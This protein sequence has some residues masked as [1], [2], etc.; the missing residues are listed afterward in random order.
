[1]TE[2]DRFAIALFGLLCIYGAA[3]VWWVGRNLPGKGKRDD[4]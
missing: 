4:D 1:M 2:T 3:A